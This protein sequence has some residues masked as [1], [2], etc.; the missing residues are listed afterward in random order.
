MLTLY[1]GNRNYSSW[2]L[3]AWLLMRQAGIEFEERMV[4]FSDPEFAAKI[5]RL[6]APPRV[7][8]LVDDGFVVWDSIAIA[9]YLAERFPQAGVWPAEQRWRARAR[10]VCAEIHAGFPA[11]RKSLPMNIEA[12]LPEVG[13]SVSAEVLREI[14]RLVTM[15]GELRSA[16]A[17]GGRFLFGNFCA[18]DAFYAPVVA[19][20]ATYEVSVPGQIR[21]YMEAIMDLEGMR[22]WCDAARAEHDFLPDEE[23]Y[24]KAPD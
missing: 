13:A 18:A 14:E 3:R 2:S 20:L 9:E 17:G 15:W 23:P 11:L 22:E 7:P 21:D 6:G 1:I 19:R 5:V 16:H 8:V 10:S 24:R 12:R 4:R